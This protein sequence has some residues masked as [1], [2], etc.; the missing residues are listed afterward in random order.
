MSL[1]REPAVWAGLVL[2]IGAV[3]GVRAIEENAN[4]VEQ[5]VAFTLPLVANLFVRQNV[6]PTSG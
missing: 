6:T 3:L 5:V 2:A 1:S 4:L